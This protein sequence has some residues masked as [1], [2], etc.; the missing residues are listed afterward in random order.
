MDRVV[1]INPATTLEGSF[2]S[3]LNDLLPRLPSESKPLLPLLLAPALGNPLQLLLQGIDLRAS[4]AIVASQLLEV[5]Y[6][7]EIPYGHQVSML[8]LLLS[9]ESSHVC[10][11]CP[12]Y[13]MI[14]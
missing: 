6:Y 11:P 9:S 4:P 3:F 12:R 1:L 13:F 2:I 14:T 5:F 8:Y 10:W 7:R